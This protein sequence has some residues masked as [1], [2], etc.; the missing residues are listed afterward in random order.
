TIAATA[1][2]SAINALTLK[3][4][5]CARWLKPVH[6][7]GFFTR[8]FDAVYKPIENGYAWSVRMLLKVWWLVLFVFLVVAVATGRWYKQTPEGF[9]PDEDQGYIV[10]AVQL[11]D[12][13]SIDR[14]TEVTNRMNNVLRDTP[15][16]ENW[17]VLGGFSLLDGTAAPNSATAFAAWKDWK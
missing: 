4:A 12:A 2:I 7:K 11:P 13:A 14:T 9:R 1:V 15:G 10:I 3:P 17:F 8:A 6:K 5:Q 16:I